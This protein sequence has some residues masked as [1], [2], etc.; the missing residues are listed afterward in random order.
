M[1]GG[2]SKRQKSQWT[3]GPL[4]DNL[5][6]STCPR[7][8]VSSRVAL[9]LIL[10]S[11]TVISLKHHTNWALFCRPVGLHFLACPSSTCLQIQYT[12]LVPPKS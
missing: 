1:T 8:S 11:T 4:R 5:S 6:L 9:N 12:L 10:L 3:A 7:A 2:K